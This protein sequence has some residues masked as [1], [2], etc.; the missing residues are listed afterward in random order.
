M[1]LRGK[2][3]AVSVVLAITGA[4]G[5]AGNTTAA[6][7]RPVTWANYFDRKL[8]LHVWRSNP[9]NGAIIVVWQRNGSKAQKWWETPMSGGYWEQQNVIS[10]KALDRW[11]NKYCSVTDWDY[12]GGAQQ[13]WKKHKV[14]SGKYQL[15]NKAGC[16][17]NPAWDSAT[18]NL[19]PPTAEGPD[20]LPRSNNVILR[21]EYNCGGPPP[22]WWQEQ[23][24]FWH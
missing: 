8:M 15:I 5:V 3:L 17:G 1:S 22:L 18:N 7:A 4:V 13:L 11:N 2:R 10:W 24:C 19:Y 14:A 6:H 12:W 16:N 20:W 23:G 9:N 21:T